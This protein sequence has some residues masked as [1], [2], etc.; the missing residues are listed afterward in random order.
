MQLQPHVY[1]QQSKQ[2]KKNVMEHYTDNNKKDEKSTANKMTV[3]EAGRLG[4]KTRARKYTPEQLSEQARRGAMTI[5]KRRPGFHA[6]IAR[7]RAKAARAKTQA[8]NQE[9]VKKEE[10]KKE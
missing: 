10:N 7:N 3:S 2:E 9:T 5:E 4:G 1:H 8:Q 6:E